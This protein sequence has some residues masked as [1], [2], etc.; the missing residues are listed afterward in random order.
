MDVDS[1]LSIVEKHSGHRGAMI[2]IL[3][4][5][6]AKYGYLPAD[7]L[8]AVAEATG[9]P[10]VDVYGI[11][12]F[13]RAFS[14]KPR[15][16]HVCTVCQGTACHV[17]GAPNIAREF[18]K[19]LAVARGETTADGEFTLETVNCLG[20]CA[21]GPIVVADG[22]YFSNVSTGRVKDILQQARA[23]FEARQAGDE[24]V[25]PVDVRCPRC[26]HT[27]M[28]AEHPLE[29]HASVA[30]M[31]TAGTRTGWLRLS[32]VYG[33]HA[34]ATENGFETGTVARVF[35]PHCAGE[36]RGAAV[37]PECEA[38]FV[39]LSV[40]GGAILQV[41]SRLGCQGHLLDLSGVNA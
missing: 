36:L 10:L 35:C 6:Q 16:K 1:V 32:A 29:G 18:E 25:F 12:T 26:N 34:F 11:A 4:D 7:A 33:A 13:Y 17:R 37:C 28:D 41:C 2:A 31:L 39:P 30:L 24:R 21:L 5:V 40:E 9:K 14:L 23:G 27:L 20:A 3:E 19:Q 38:A 22:H 15:G 8:E